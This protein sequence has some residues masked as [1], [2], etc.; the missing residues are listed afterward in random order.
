MD[1]QRYD[2]IKANIRYEG[3]GSVQTK[4][5]PYVVVSNPIGTKHGTI[6]TVMPLTSKIKKENMPVHGCIKANNVNGLSFYSMV[7]GEQPVT[8]SKDEIKEKLGTITNQKEK[9]MIN[10]ICYNTFFFGENINWEE[11]LA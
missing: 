8:I 3:T 11:V 2:I 4:E 9:N 1:L 5:R 7:L 6:I 10:K